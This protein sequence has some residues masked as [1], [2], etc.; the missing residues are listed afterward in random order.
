MESA[1]P[2]V[3]NGQSN[4]TSTIK[5]ANLIILKIVFSIQ[6]ERFM[7]IYFPTSDTSVCRLISS[8]LY[9]CKLNLV[10]QQGQ[11]V[12]L[13][14]KQNVVLHV[15]VHVYCIHFLDSGYSLYVIVKGKTG[16]HTKLSIWKHMVLYTLRGWNFIP[17][18]YWWYSNIS[19]TRNNFIVTYCSAGVGRTGIFIALDY[20]LDQAKAEGIIDVLG[21]VNHL[22]E[23]RVNMVQ[24]VVGS[25]YCNYLWIC[26]EKQLY[27]CYSYV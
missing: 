11:Q 17:Q 22:R 18:Y 23:N 5:Y 21:C 13:F 20:L 19:S 12:K 26:L 1:C 25:R 8:S 27:F 16:Y 2:K 24:T 15:H 6:F 4:G 10:H 7:Q 14:Q 9:S 3:I